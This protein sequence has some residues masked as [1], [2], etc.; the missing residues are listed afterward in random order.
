[1]IRGKHSKIE[2]SPGLASANPKKALLMKQEKAGRRAGKKLTC[3]PTVL[4]N[5]IAEL[6]TMGVPKSPQQIQK[7][8]VTS[9]S[10]CR[11]LS[12]PLLGDRQP[13]RE[14]VKNLFWRTFAKRWIE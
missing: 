10:Q 1:M 12:S 9:H 4:Q 7:A 8:R 13:S 11:S 6:L 5:L 14:D 3:A 2:P